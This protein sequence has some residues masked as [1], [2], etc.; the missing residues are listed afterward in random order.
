[1][2]GK[3]LSLLA[4]NLIVLSLVLT[5]CSS[6]GAVE[7]EPGLTDEQYAQL[8]KELAERGVCNVDTPEAASRLAGFPVA[9]PAFLPDGV[10]LNSKYMVS[11]HNAGLSEIM[12]PKFKW[13]DVTTTYSTEGEK[14]PVIIL[15][16]ST[17]EFNTGRGEP[18]EICG[19]AV[20][21]Q[22]TTEPGLACGWKDNGI[23]YYL[24]GK[25]TGP[26]DEAT[27]EEILC[28]VGHD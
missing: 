25:L 26:L 2:K 19:R 13:I 22:Y 8:E 3:E 15:I 20:A 14:D 5:C 18:V 10:M 28:S 9:T 11:D 27:M 1:M 7:S 16:Q 12:T 21:R 24:T 4:G 17:H 6:P 23:W